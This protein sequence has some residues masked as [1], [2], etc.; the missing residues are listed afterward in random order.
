MMV[1]NCAIHPPTPCL[2]QAPTNAQKIK[3]ENQAGHS[4]ERAMKGHGGPPERKP[5]A[6]IPRFA[7]LHYNYTKKKKKKKGGGGRA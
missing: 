3:K 6:A 1:V 4:S 7:Q 2:W 5:R